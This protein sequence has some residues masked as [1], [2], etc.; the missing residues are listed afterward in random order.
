MTQIKLELE[1]VKKETIIK[2]LETELKIE[3]INSKINN[4]LNLSN[5]TKK[6][7]LDELEDVLKGI[8]ILMKERDE[9]EQNY[10]KS[11]INVCEL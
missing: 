8:E 4:L 3:K 9:I 10:L 5:P 1:L 2:R 6:L 11:N 7:C